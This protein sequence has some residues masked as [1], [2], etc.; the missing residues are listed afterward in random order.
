MLVPCF[1]YILENCKKKDVAP[2]GGGG[3]GGYSGFQVTGVIE[4]G[5]KWKP[6]TS[7]GLKQPSPP[8]KR[9]GLHLT[10]TPSPQ[11]FQIALND[12]TPK[13]SVLKLS[14]PKKYLPKFSYPKKTPKS[15]DHPCQFST[16]VPSPPPDAARQK[17]LFCQYKPFAFLPL[18]LPFC[19]LITD[20]VCH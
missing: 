19:I 9:L 16:G 18:S 5:Q 12:I 14:Y 7:L 15:F 20:N 13:Q 1:S 8:P 17:L 6:K 3:G 11:N 10:P 4:W 2:Q